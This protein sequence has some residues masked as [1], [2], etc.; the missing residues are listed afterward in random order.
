MP[1]SSRTGLIFE[2]DNEETAWVPKQDRLAR[3]EFN[4]TDL[5]FYRFMND[6]SF[7]RFLALSWSKG[8]PFCGRP[9]LRRLKQLRNDEV[10]KQMRAKHNLADDEPLTRS[11]QELGDGIPEVIPLTIP[12]QAELPAHELRVMSDASLYAPVMFELTAANVDYFAQAVVQEDDATVPIV[13]RPEIHRGE[14][15]IIRE[16]K[17]HGKVTFHTKVKC[18]DGKR[19]KIQRSYQESDEDLEFNQQLRNR[20]LAE[21][22]QAAADAVGLDDPA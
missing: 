5:V 20:I 11:R 13:H 6:T 7:A 19:R 4:G 16:E 10:T 3:V 18:A 1:T 17:E 14:N 2:R 8:T 22:N 21:V 9:F 12:A 15:W